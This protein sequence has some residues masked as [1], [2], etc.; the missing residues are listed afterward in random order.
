[1]KPGA[2]LGGNWGSTFDELEALIKKLFLVKYVIIIMAKM[3]RI[4]SYIIIN[5]YIRIIKIK[6]IRTLFL[7]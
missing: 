6:I 7:N 5:S 2:H 3:V 1:L 4:N